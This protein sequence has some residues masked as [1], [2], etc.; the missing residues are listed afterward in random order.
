MGNFSA[1]DQYADELPQDSPDEP[2]P[3]TMHPWLKWGLIGSALAGGGFFV[4]Q[5]DPITG[6]LCCAAGLAAISGFRLGASR[7]FASVLGFTLAYR[8]APALGTEYEYEFSKVF[9]TSGLTNRFMAIAWVAVLISLI[10]FLVSC[11]LINLFMQRRRKLATIDSY[12][13][14]LA[15][16]GEVC[17]GGLLLLGGIVFLEPTIQASREN[18]SR[19]GQSTS[20]KHWVTRVANNTRASQVGP[21][22]EKYNPFENIDAL[23]KIGK[24]QG[25]VRVL[26]N[27]DHLKNLVRH[28][29]IA[30][31]KDDPEMELALKNLNEDPEIR[32]ILESGTISRSDAW[33]LLSHPAVKDL[34]DQ[35]KFLERATQLVM[36][37]VE[38]IEQEQ[39]RR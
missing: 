9:D 7:L 34:V 26:T 20:P 24:T 5:G 37:Q 4:F 31:L 25:T 16:V 32:E 39:A 1:I 10:V 30:S 2:A 29:S 6:T 19:D 13:G 27:P 18:S 17:V 28:P 12:L 14:S 21:I 36:Q 8:F 35:K 23:R 33:K 15:G 38:A 22:V 11:K 3:V